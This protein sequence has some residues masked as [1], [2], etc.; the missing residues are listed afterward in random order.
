MLKLIIEKSY[1]G[2]S[3]RNRSGVIK[4]EQLT[5]QQNGVNA[6]SHKKATPM[7]LAFIILLVLFFNDESKGN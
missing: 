4:D 5:I 7:T 6:K 2:I 3:K 1:S